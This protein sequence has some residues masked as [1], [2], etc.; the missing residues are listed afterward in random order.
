MEQWECRDVLLCLSH[1]T[2]S[3]VCPFVVGKRRKRVKNS[4]SLYDSAHIEFAELV[5]TANPLYKQEHGED[6]TA[7][8]FLLTII[9]WN[10]FIVCRTGEDGSP[11][12]PTDSWILSSPSYKGS[13]ARCH[14]SFSWPTW[15]HHPKILYLLLCP[16]TFPAQR[17]S[18]ANLQ[19]LSH[20]PPQP[21]LPY[22]EGDPGSAFYLA[23][24][25]PILIKPFS[26]VS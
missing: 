13:L 18:P 6:E 14:V 5:I 25:P 8:M 12:T 24:L 2:L 20:L 16:P 26:Q 19:P 3:N 10:Q 17:W 21:G 4:I 23:S 9:A 7:A 22:P 11:T 1:T 15:W